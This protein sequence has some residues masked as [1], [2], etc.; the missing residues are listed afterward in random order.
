M[1]KEVDVPVIFLQNIIYIHILQLKLTVT[2]N[3]TIINKA[4]IQGQKWK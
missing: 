1:T 2:I 4:D 3:T